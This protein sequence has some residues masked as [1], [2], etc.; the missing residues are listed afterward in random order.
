MIT[1]KTN[2]V[3][4]KTIILSFSYLLKK[5]VSL[6]IFKV[7]WMLYNENI[8]FDYCEYKNIYQ[9]INS[10]INVGTITTMTIGQ[11]ATLIRTLEE[12]MIIK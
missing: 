9:L 7:H 5:T 4:Q 8:T 11:K 3:K 6:L 12:K 1:S 2:S 10:L